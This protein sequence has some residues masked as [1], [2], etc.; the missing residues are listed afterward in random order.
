MNEK[1]YIGGG[2]A[3]GRIPGYGGLDQCSPQR[4]AVDKSPE[5]IS[6]KL[7]ELNAL[8]SELRSR[9]AILANSLVGSE[10]ED[11]GN[12]CPAPAD[13]LSQLEGLRRLT[14]EIGRQVVRANQAVGN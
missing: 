5:T 12:V 6:S 1:S 7:G 4:A 11:P 3:S 8:L 13:V 10:P 14:C 2:V 9:A